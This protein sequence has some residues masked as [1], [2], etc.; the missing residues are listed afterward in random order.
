MTGVLTQKG[1]EKMDPENKAA[2]LHTKGHQEL[3]AATGT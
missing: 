3:P 1:H 2:R